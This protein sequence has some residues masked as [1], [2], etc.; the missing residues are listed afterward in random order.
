[1]VKG[2]V[3]RHDIN[4]DEVF[5]VVAWL[6]LMHLLIALMAHKGWE[7]HHMDV[8]LAFLNRDL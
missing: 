4:Y 3:Q 5:T 2:Y 6:E 8:K 1:M 7:V